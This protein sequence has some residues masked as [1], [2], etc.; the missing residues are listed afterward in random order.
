MARDTR[1]AFLEALRKQN[2]ALAQAFEEALAALRSEAL[3]DEIEAAIRARDVEAIIR[4]LSMDSAASMSG[5]YEAMRN[6][7]AAGAAYQI[8]TAPRA[9]IRGFEVRFDGNHPRAETYIRQSGGKFITEIT[10]DTRL[11]IRQFLQGISESDRSYR[12]FA[13]QLVGEMVGNQRKGGLIGL[14]SRQARAVQNL[15][16][17]LGDPERLRQTFGGNPDNWPFKLRNRSFDRSIAQAIREGRALDEKRIRQATMFYADRQLRHRAKTI[18]WT[19][20]NKAMNA[21]RAESIQ[22][23]IDR[24]E[25][26]ATAVTVKWRAAFDN[27]V[28]DSH[29]DINGDEVAWGERFSNGLRY[30]H[31]DGAP[32]EEVINCRCDAFFRVDWASLA[33]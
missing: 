24:G 13:R 12:Q 30:P 17:I 25:I 26:P 9:L 31:E 27:R 19:E 2:T 14:H 29:A 15:R 22:Q 16:N 20:G 23:M 32:A 8:S 3:L 6:A 7:F 28:R 33:S 4:A 5:F 18:A 21:G 11:L 10:E 1:A